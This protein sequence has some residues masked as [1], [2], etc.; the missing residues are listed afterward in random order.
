MSAPPLHQTQVQF[1]IIGDLAHDF[2]VL[3][4][5]VNS[6]VHSLSDNHLRG[7]KTLLEEKLKSKGT[8]IT[9]PSSADELIN[10]ISQYWDFLNIE[11]AQLVVRYLGKEDLQA[12]LKRYEE[13]LKIFS[14]KIT[15]N[16][17][18]N[19][20]SLQRILEIKDLL[21]HQFG[22]DRDSFQFIGFPEGVGSVT[23]KVIL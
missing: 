3:I 23:P 1:P 16:A 4:A 8:P 14:T 10:F 22:I 5:G 9:I 6:E 13:M 2:A 15:V 18:P 19:S 11:F 7:L 20:F 17:E 12:Q 21:A